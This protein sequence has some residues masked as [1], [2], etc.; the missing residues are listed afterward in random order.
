VLG[1][2][3]DVLSRPGALR[4]SAAGTLARLPMSMVGIGIVLM[5]QSL[6]GSYG[7]AGR[8]SAV[9]IVAQAVCSPQ[10][11]R[12]VDRHGQA[13]IMR[14]AVGVAAVGLVGLVTAAVLSAP[15]AVLYVAAAVTG[16][17]IGSFGSLV[18]AR[19]SFLLGDDERR[20][21]TAYSLESALDELVF[22]IGPVAATLLATGVTPSA[23]LVVPLVAMVIGGYWFCSLRATEPPVAPA[24][25]PRPRG[26]V[27]RNPA[28]L[29]L[30]LVFVAMG[31]IF[32]ANDVSTVAFA[33]E[34]GQKSLAGPVLAV[35]AAGSL[36]SGLLYGTRHWKRPL[37]QRFAN[38]TVALAAGVTLFFFVHSLPVLSAVMFVTGFAIAPTLINGN[39]MVQQLVA[40]ERLTEGLTWVGTSLGV[41]VS[42]GS[43]IAGAQIDAH[44]SHGGF[45]V[46][47]V[48]AAVAVIAVLAGYRTLRGR[49][50]GHVHDAIEPESP[51]ATGGAAVAAAELAE[52]VEHDRTRPQPDPDR[53]AGPA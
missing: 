41:G 19:W 32:G 16:A 35:F 11:A 33:D 13:R 25:A 28:M 7:L 8:V 44:G 18:R 53:P 27:L 50:D 51:S 48:S 24:D 20:I 22:V 40:P 4:F 46:A 34:A 17:A 15:E 12:L 6:Y 31:S 43:S 37:H 52:C 42:V 39:G 29:V 26:S 49:H 30:M 2:Y 47:M 10:L 3:K 14:P 5:V 9:Y 45:R 23:G 38:G 21:H 36:L 1:P